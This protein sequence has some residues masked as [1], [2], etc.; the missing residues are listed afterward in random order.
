MVPWI[1]S[2]VNKK[3]DFWFV[4]LS[5]RTISWL[6]NLS[7]NAIP[8]FSEWNWASVLETNRIGGPLISITKLGN[9]IAILVIQF[10]FAK[11]IVGLLPLYGSQEIKEKGKKQWKALSAFVNVLT[12]LSF[13]PIKGEILSSRPTRCVCNFPKRKEHENK[14]D[15]LFLGPT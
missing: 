9:S 10:Y 5:F 11:H 12:S 13:K 8:H 6:P 4:S 7:S 1:Y 3:W 15:N 2:G 14:N